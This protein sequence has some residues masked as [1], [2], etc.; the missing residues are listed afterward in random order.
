M[1]ITSPPHTHDSTAGYSLVQSEKT[2]RGAIARLTGLLRRAF[3][4]SRCSVTLVRLLHITSPEA[5]GAWRSAVPAGA[6]R[7]TGRRAT[8]RRGQ[9]RPERGEDPSARPPWHRRR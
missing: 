3:L 4:G 1:W 9:A 2:R 8:S 6:E 5:R 7:A